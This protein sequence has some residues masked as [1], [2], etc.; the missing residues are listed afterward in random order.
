MEKSL[1]LFKPDVY[2][3]GLQQEILT[4]LDGLPLERADHFR[5]RF[6]PEGVF[7]LWPRIYGWRWTD[8]LMRDF[9][10]RPLDVHV[11]IGPRAAETVIGFKDA[12][13]DQRGQ[14]NSYRN[15][16]HSPD[17]PEAFEREYQYLCSIRADG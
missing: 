15:L 2:E 12:L 3:R 6:T 8:S 14:A 4:G 17:G 7:E 13:R 10:S 9:P 11:L 5:V 1:V 16:L